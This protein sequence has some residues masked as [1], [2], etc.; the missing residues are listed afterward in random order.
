ME[1]AVSVSDDSEVACFS[2]NRK[3]LLDFDFRWTLIRSSL[4]GGMEARLG[5]CYHF[6]V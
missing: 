3:N 1:I 6:F 2:F 5:E 4:A